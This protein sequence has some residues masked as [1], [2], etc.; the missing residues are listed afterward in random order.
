[1]CNSLWCVLSWKWCLRS[2]QMVWGSNC[3]LWSGKFELVTP[4]LCSY[5]STGWIS[6][7]WKYWYWNLLPYSFSFFLLGVLT[8][9]LF[10]CS[11][12]PDIIPWLLLDLFL[13]S[14][15]PIMVLPWFFRGRLGP[16]PPKLGP[17]MLLP[18]RLGT[19]MLGNNTKENCSEQK[20]LFQ[21][22]FFSEQ[23]KNC[24]E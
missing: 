8:P 13:W 12:S 7:T 17:V 5:R 1:M 14:F 15:P 10:S 11:I 23:Q 2:E 20:K 22:I 21:T 6:Y 9:D 18:A 4:T 24:S 19:I 3:P 16:L